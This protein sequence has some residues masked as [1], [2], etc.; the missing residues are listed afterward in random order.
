MSCAKLVGIHDYD[1]VDAGQRDSDSGSGSNPIPDCSV[2]LSQG[3]VCPTQLVAGVNQSCVFGAGMLYCWGYPSPGAVATMSDRPVAVPAM[4]P[5]VQVSTSTTPWASTSDVGTTCFVD[6]TSNVW[7]WGDSESDQLQMNSTTAGMPT[8]MMLPGSGVL[9]VAVGGDHVCDM[10]PGA[11]Y[12]W[13]ADANDQLDDDAHD[14]LDPVGKQFFMMT[15][16][17]AMG[18][19]HTCVGSGGLAKCW[20]ANESGE[21]GDGTHVDTTGTLD[22][23]VVVTSS[24]Q[25]TLD[26]V[27]ALSAGAS[28]TCAL[29]GSASAADAYCWGANDAGQ[30]GVDTGMVA[31]ASKVPAPTQFTAIASGTAT[32]CAIDVERN[33]WCWGSNKLGQASIG[34]ATA[35]VVPASVPP[36]QTSVTDAIAIAVG[37][38]HACAT[39]ASGAIVCWGGNS[40][41]QLGDNKLNHMN[42]GACGSASGN[43]DCSWLPVEVAMP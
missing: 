22:T 34:P 28:F 4:N 15:S 33:V 39:Q 25:T 11:F 24:N 36:T 1:G 30:L 7:C 41:G 38:N 6:N 8:P 16:I 14:A 32:T 37:D 40:A 42:A 29:S 27:I 26:N 19:S 21:L 17:V 35:M 5:P 2:G 10:L 23:V 43:D 31:T 20:G 12:C 3:G 9:S 18:R 13:G